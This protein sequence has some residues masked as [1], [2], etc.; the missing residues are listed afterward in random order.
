MQKRMM[1]W[2]IMN[3]IMNGMDSTT[4]VPQDNATRAQVAAMIERYIENIVFA[5]G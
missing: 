3:G 2:A 1:G 5:V 4:L